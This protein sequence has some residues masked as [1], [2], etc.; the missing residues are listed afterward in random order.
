MQIKYFFFSFLLTG[1]ILSNDL[2]F[3]TP[4]AAQEVKV[5]VLYYRMAS[6]GLSISPSTCLTAF[7]AYICSEDLLQLA[8]RYAD[9]SPAGHSLK[10]NDIVKRVF[11]QPP[12]PM[13]LCLSGQCVEKRAFYR[14]ISGLHASINI[15]LSARYLL[16]GE[17]Q[18]AAQ[19]L[20]VSFSH[21][22]S[23]YASFFVVL[24]TN[25]AQC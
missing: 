12:F 21:L 24:S 4:S 13:I 15:H 10:R 14:L 5:G 23:H 20:S 3:P 9:V 16:D 17:T 1:H 22:Y 8:G 6:F 25:A 11:I 7:S 2:F 18:T 19:A